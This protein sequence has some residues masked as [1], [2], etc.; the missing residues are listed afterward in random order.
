MHQHK[1][2]AAPQINRRQFVTGLAMGGILAGVGLRSGNLFAAPQPASGSTV[3]S[4]THFDLKIGQHAVNF[5]GTPRFATTVNN[6]LPAPIL[7]FKEGEQ[8][9][10]KVQNSLSVDSSIHWHGLI[11]PANMDGVPG[12]SFAGIKPG[13]S[14]T[15]RF[16]VQQSGTYWYHSHSGFQE[17]TGLYG[18]IIIDPKE[19]EPFH[20][21]RDYTVLLSDWT[22]ENPVDVYAKLK[23]MSHYYNFNERTLDGHLAGD[24]T[25]AVYGRPIRRG[26]CGTGCA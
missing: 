3:L 13:D 10:I 16:K 12:L 6:S 25:S 14:Y 22:D 4:G 9:T 24:S 20:Y 19:P 11:L 17:Q 23:K 1:K 15:Y 8:V 21:D 2:L 5:T 26:R 18:A 7:R